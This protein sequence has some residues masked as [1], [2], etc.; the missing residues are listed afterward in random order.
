MYDNTYRFSF[1]SG[2]DDGEDSY[3][4]SKQR[5]IQFEVTHEDD[6]EWTSVMLDFADFLSSIYG[7]DV[8]DKLRF[9]DYGGCSAR[10]QEYSIDP[11][12][13]EFKFE[14]SDKDEEWS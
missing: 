5:S 4:Y 10:A 2:Y 12:Q 3:G 13:S 9:V 11:T 14:K 7:Y 6:V 8:K 1:E